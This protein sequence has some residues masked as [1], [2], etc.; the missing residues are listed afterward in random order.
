MR[1]IPVDDLH[2]LYWIQDLVSPALC[3]QILSTPWLDLEWHSLPLQASWPRRTIMDHELPWLPAWND[4]IQQQW[5]TISHIIGTIELGYLMGATRWWVDLPG[6][7]CDV[8]TDGELP[9][10]IHIMWQGTDSGLGT[11]FY[12]FKS[13]DSLRFHCPM[14]ANQG[15]VMVNRPDHNGYRHLQWHGMTTPVPTGTIRVSSYIPL[16]SY[17]I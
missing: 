16:A 3:D 14:I 4:E 7:T 12:H 2:N 6:F 5:S 11:Q 8:H 1:L 17:K 15:Y 13:A 10:S 9:G